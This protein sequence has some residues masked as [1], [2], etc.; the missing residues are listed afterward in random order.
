[1]SGIVC[2]PHFEKR[3]TLGN[4]ADGIF[5]LLMSKESTELALGDWLLEFKLRF[6]TEGLGTSMFLAL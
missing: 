4:P 3:P 2:T 6:D 5:Y 1:M